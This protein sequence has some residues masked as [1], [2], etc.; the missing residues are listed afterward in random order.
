MKIKQTKSFNTISERIIYGLNFIYSEFVPIKSEK[1]DEKSQR[2]VHKLMG[3]MIDKLYVAPEFLNLA[4][5]TDETYEW[6]ALNNSNLELDKVY[7]SI[8]KGLYDFYKYLYISFLHGESKE[9]C[10]S[11]TN[12]TLSKNKA[13]YKPLYKTFLN[14]IGIDIK[15]GKV[16]T[17]FTAESDTLKGLKLLA[18]KT[19]VNI[20]RWTPYV[21]LNFA[22]C[23]FTGDFSFLLTRVDSVVGLDGLLL[24]IED[25]YMTSG[26][27]KSIKC[28][29]GASGFAFSISFQN[30]VGGFIIGYNPRKYWQFYFGSMNSIGVKAMLEDFENL[31]YDLQKHLINVCKTCNGCLGC[32]KGGR[33]KILAV[34][35][36]HDSK[37]YNLCNDNYAR[38]NWET[39]NSDLALQLFKYHTEQEN[40][41]TNWKKKK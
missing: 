14:E 27:E 23:S 37:E 32:T 35:V 40:Y 25:N 29:F 31:D 4:V 39:I 13:S 11:I 10:L 30:K 34:K 41:G 8:F 9:N 38:H 5:N 24:E 22:C 6:Y 12:K 3:Q 19:P 15:K 17:M 20:N 18:E 1:V 7:K 26:Y 33:N 28:S 21:L 2:K 16:E 36:K